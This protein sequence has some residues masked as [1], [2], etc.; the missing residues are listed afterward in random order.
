MVRFILPGD[1]YH[2]VEPREP[3]NPIVMYSHYSLDD[4]LFSSD[5]LEYQSRQLLPWLRS[6]AFYR[7][8]PALPLKLRLS[9][10]H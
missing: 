10:C 2:C 3:T 6:I 9:D 4:P 7:R 1:Q 5:T 8:M